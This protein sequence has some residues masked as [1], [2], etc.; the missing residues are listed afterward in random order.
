MKLITLTNVNWNEPV[1]ATAP[2]LSLLTMTG[3]GSSDDL[4]HLHPSG[5]ATPLGR[6]AAVRTG[7]ATRFGGSGHTFASTL[8]SSISFSVFSSSSANLMRFVLISEFGSSAGEKSMTHF[9]TQ[10]NTKVMEVCHDKNR[11]NHNVQLVSSLVGKTSNWRGMWV[12][13]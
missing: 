10:I 11:S 4:K 13:P 6:I 5:Q 2:Y 12:I 7:G 3:S 1:P 9:V 8:F